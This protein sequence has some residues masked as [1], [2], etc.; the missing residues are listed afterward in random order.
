MDDVLNALVESIR[1]NSLYI[2]QR[3]RDGAS[4]NVIDALI[5]MNVGRTHALQLIGFGQE[6]DRISIEERDMIAKARRDAADAK[7]GAA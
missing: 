2:A 7:G 4:D 6:A 1:R 5:M 3:I